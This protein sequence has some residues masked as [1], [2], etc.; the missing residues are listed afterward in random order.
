MLVIPE[1][2]ILLF[3]F[4]AG[5]FLLISTAQRFKA[6]WHNTLT[7]VCRWYVDEKGCLR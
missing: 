6:Y 5:R 1:K 2:A 7:L 3:I 4:F